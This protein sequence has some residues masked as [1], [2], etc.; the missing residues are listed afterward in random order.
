MQT[1]FYELEANKSLFCGRDG[2]AKYKLS[3]ID[4]ER[5]INS[6]KSNLQKWTLKLKK[7]EIN[8]NTSLNVNIRE[9]G[10]YYV[11][12]PVGW[13]STILAGNIIEFGI[14][15][16]DDVSSKLNYTLN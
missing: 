13:N 6:S 16:S 4:K 2:V 3:D 8:I 15:G 10:D 12:T 7:R 1:R 11:I 9:E 14:H 5:V